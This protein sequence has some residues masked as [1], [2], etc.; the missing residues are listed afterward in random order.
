MALRLERLPSQEPRWDIFQRWWQRT[1]EAI[2]SNFNALADTVAAVAAAQAAAD[3]AEL[4]AAAAVTAADTVASAAELANSYPE[5]VSISATDAGASVTVS[6]SAHNRVYA[7]GTTVAVN[8]GNLT[9]LAYST[10]YWIAYD[11]ASRAGGAVTY[12]A[13]TTSQGN[14]VNN[15]DRHFVGA[16]ATPDAGGLDNDGVASLPPGGVNPL[17]LDGGDIP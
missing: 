13:Y 16:V 3:A 17:A 14:A 1:M 9:G 5:G 10:S 12:V 11:Q 4:A 2:E 8:A 15:P 6:I 7:S